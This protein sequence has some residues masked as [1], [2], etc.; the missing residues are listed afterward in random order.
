MVGPMISLPLAASLLENVEAQRLFAHPL[1]HVFG[2][3]FYFNSHML[4]M[5]IAA[6]IMVMIFPRMANNRKKSAVP[7]GIDNF[8]EAILSYLR[9]EVFQPALGVNAD[10]FAPFLWTVFFFIL[11]LNLLGIIPMEQIIGLINYEFGTH[12]PIWGGA[13]TGNLM[14]TAALAITTFFV[15]HISGIW[16]RIRVQMDPTLDPHHTGNDHLKPRGHGEILGS[17]GPDDA[18]DVRIAAHAGDGLPHAHGIHRAPQGQ[19][20]PV[21]AALGFWD[22][23]KNFTPTVPKIIYPGVFVLELFGSLIK[24]FALC[25]RLFANMI[26]GHLV[27]AALIS[28]I[29]IAENY[30]MRGSVSVIVVLSCVAFSLL[31]VLVC[32]IQAYIF[33]FLATLFIATAVSPEH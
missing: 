28:M 16:Q 2:H 18:R 33:M 22:Y 8:F 24:P 6:L 21:A 3:P 15:I 11:F 14:V 20:F 13:A 1:F 4:M 26:A 29:F 19:I 27:L 7:R 5:L 23:W 12:W 25:M 32:F 9:T 31:E 10:R 30:V 17:V